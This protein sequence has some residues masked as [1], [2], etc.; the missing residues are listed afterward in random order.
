MVAREEAT[1]ERTAILNKA[2]EMIGNRGIDHGEAFLNMQH[3][4][5]IWSAYLGVEIGPM[6][7]AL[8][9]AL[10]KVSRAKMGNNLHGD[11]YVDMAGYAA[12][13]GE[14]AKKRPA[15]GKG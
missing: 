3:T 12:I 7:V 6:D 8:M 1:N 14:V 2:I 9:L 11:H 5:K 15:P 4:A 10:V 13:A